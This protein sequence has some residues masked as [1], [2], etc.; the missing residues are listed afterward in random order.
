[1]GFR[2]R[3]TICIAEIVFW[4]ENIGTLIIIVN[5][6]SFKLP[7]SKNTTACNLNYIAIAIIWHSSCRI[8]SLSLYNPSFGFSSCKSRN[9]QQQLL[10]SLQITLDSMWIFLLPL[11]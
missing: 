5:G 6:H 11:S 10:P 7:H 3:F 9:K 4:L 2:S 1:M 8:V